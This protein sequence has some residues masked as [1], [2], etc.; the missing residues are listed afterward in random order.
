MKFHRPGL[1][2]KSVTPCK[3]CMDMIVNIILFP[4]HSDGGLGL[5]RILCKSSR[6]V[7]QK[8]FLLLEYSEKWFT[9]SIKCPDLWLDFSYCMTK[10]LNFMPMFYKKKQSIDMCQTDVWW[11]EEA[12]LPPMGN[13]KV[14]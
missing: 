3:L 14:P 7:T 1:S 10:N 11:S 2:D 5:M 8:P 4:K 6:Y 9:M 12:L 13:L